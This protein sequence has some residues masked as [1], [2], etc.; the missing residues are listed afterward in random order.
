MVATDPIGHAALK[1]T[2]WRLLPLLFLGYGIAYI[3]RL[4][5]SFA[6]LQMNQDLHF[7]A[8]VYGLSLAVSFT[9]AGALVLLIRNLSSSARAPG[10]SVTAVT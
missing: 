7:S 9:V 8:T 5:I 1:K 10:A 2:S 3:D 4:N 6:A